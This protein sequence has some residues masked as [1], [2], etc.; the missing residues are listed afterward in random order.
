MRSYHRCPHNYLLL[1]SNFTII[2]CALP[3]KSNLQFH[4]FFGKINFSYQKIGFSNTL[5][6]YIHD[7]FKTFLVPQRKKH[8][9]IFACW[10]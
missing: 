1:I 8:G 6:A 9:A 10:I 7:I 4:L 2:F 3:L 5:L